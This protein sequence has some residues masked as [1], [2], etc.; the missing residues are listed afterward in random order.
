[1]KVWNVVYKVLA[2]VALL[3]FLQLNVNA[4]AQDQE[5]EYT[6]GS[7]DMVR[8]TV[9]GQDDLTVETRLSNIGIIRYPFLGDI[10]LVGKTVNQ[11][12]LL[13]DEGLR[14]DYLVDPSVSVTVLEYRPFFISGE[15]R[16]PGGYPFQPGL[17]IEK[18][19]ALAGGYTERASKSVVE[20]RR[21]IGGNEQTIEMATSEIVMPG[22][23]IT[24]QQRFF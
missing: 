6:L 8:I 5:S 16:K 4:Y 11:V 2:L 7:G 18:A 20:V 17:T 21:S 24:V 14:G 22:D 9:F 3:S 12:E 1:M 13:I 15:V 23:I 10:Q 19:A